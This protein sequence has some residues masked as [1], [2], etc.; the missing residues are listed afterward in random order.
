VIKVCNENALSLDKPKDADAYVAAVLAQ[1]ATAA[2]LIK[3][4]VIPVVEGAKKAVKA[5]G[6]RIAS[7]LTRQLTVELRPMRMEL[8]KQSKAMEELMK[9][10]SRMKP[11]RSTRADSES[12]EPPP[13]PRRR[14]QPSK[15]PLL[16]QE[17]RKEGQ[18]TGHAE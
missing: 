15:P 6:I 12:D 9:K 8:E 17:T 7:A 13:K 10:V 2:A 16:L 1:Q 4:V 11:G 3:Q 14:E 5:E 18:V